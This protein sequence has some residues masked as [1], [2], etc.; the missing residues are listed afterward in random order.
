MCTAREAAQ[1]TLSEAERAKHAAERHIRPEKERAAYSLQ[2]IT[3]LKACDLHAV[4]KARE[5]VQ[6]WNTS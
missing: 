3:D 6:W 5:S 4:Q 1:R 2:L